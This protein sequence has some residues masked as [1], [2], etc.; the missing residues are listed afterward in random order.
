MNSLVMETTTASQERALRMI[1]EIEHSIEYERLQAMNELVGALVGTGVVIYAFGIKKVLSFLIKIIDL[2]IKIIKIC[3]SKLGDL[4]NW[5]MSDKTIADTKAGKFVAASGNATKTIG[6][7]LFES[8]FTSINLNGYTLKTDIAKICGN[9]NRIYYNLDFNPLYMNLVMFHKKP[10]IDRDDLYKHVYYIRSDILGLKQPV[11]MDS[12]MFQ[13][14]F[15]N[16]VC[17]NDVHTYTLQDALEFI[18]KYDNNITMLQDCKDKIIN[19]STQSIKQL[20]TSKAVLQKQTEGFEFDVNQQIN[21]LLEYQ[22]TILSDFFVVFAILL[23][24]MRVA[25]YQSKAIIAMADS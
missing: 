9:I 22:K 3:I 24:Y 11:T 25:R 15:K 8:Y 13:A 2:M 20:E 6:A 17:D 23:D 4:W 10:F 12:K 19:T 18:D 5:F 14:K 1:Y 21:W 16:M 7:S